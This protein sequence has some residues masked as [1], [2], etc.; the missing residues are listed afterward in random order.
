MYT[1]LKELCS[2]LFSDSEIK[3]IEKAYNFAEKAHAG[4]KRQSGEPY[5]IHPVHVAYYVLTRHNLFD[6]ST[7]CAAL[8]HDTIEDTEVT[9]ED[10][11]KEFGEDIARLVLSVTNCNNISFKDKNEEEVYNNAAILRNMLSDIRTIIIKSCDRLHNM[12]TLEYK[13]PQSRMRKSTQTFCF[14]VPLD[15]AIG[16]N[17]PAKELENL[18]FRF[19]H[20]EKYTHTLKLKRDFEDT[21]CDY[22]AKMSHKLQELLNS[23]HIAYEWDMHMKSFYDIYKGLNKYHRL[24]KIPGLITVKI[25]VSREAECYKILELL[26]SNYNIEMVKD[27]LGVVSLDTYRTIRL[28][29]KAFKNYHLRVEICTKEMALFNNYGYAALVN[30]LRGRNISDVHQVIRTN[31][32]FFRTL[33]ELGDYYEDNRDLIKHAEQELFS[34]K[35]NVYT[36]DNRIISL[37]VGSTV[38]DFAYFI[39]SDIGR[40]ATDA[41][42]NNK[43]VGVDYVLKDEDQVIVNCNP[44]TK[45][46]PSE[47]E[48][49]KTTRARIR[50]LE[51]LNI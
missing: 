46:L 35:I 3:L 29:T 20:P 12:E 26:K 10:L 48:H 42:V 16:A 47:I 17:K 6:A 8:L 45:R 41:I 19:L 4:K 25:V 51:Q 23:T 7:V 33:T 28:D 15:Y 39:H 49:V 18:C 24:S 14:Y 2:K 50:I 38:L 43:K 44:N 34:P 30:E 40:S 37:P 32:N 21:Y 27:D 9:Y 5:I 31:S 11:V 13:N 22:I 1:E 36:R